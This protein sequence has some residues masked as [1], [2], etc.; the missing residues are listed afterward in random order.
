[1]V[2]KYISEFTGVELTQILVNL[3][4][5][6]GFI[7]VNTNLGADLCEHFRFHVRVTRL[8]EEKILCLG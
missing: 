3:I 5:F 1:V 4:K 7:E 6:E 2:T 8:H